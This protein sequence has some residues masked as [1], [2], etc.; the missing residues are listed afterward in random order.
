M[1]KDERIVAIV[2]VWIYIFLSFTAE[3]Y[4][5][6]ESP[7]HKP[8][9]WLLKG[10][11]VHKILPATPTCFSTKPCLTRRRKKACQAR[12]G[13]LPV[14]PSV[15][16]E[17]KAI[18][19]SKLS[20]RKVDL[21]EWEGCPWLGI[22]YSKKLE[23]FVTEDGGNLLKHKNWNKNKGQPVMYRYKDSGEHCATF[24]SSLVG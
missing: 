8:E 24:C 3:M 7:V 10:L 6:L 17:H 4:G 15:S 12:N 11:N 5:S 19:Q 21:G 16:E 20:D 2:F 14:F 22:K 18:Y 1:I 23:K 9:Y 13:T